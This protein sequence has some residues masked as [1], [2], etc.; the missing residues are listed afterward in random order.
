MA[1]IAVP[2]LSRRPSAPPPRIPSP[3]QAGLLWVL[4]MVLVIAAGVAVA[5]VAALVAIRTGLPLER[6]IEL[7]LDPTGSP[8][9]TTPTWIAISILASDLVLAL[10]IW[11]FLRRH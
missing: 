1:A 6:A 11:R 5:G 9:V 7:L 10:L 8:L 2:R 3:L 4:A